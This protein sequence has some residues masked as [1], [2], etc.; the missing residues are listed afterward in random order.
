MATPSDGAGRATTRGCT[1][2]GQIRMVTPSAMGC[3]DCLRIGAWWV[4]LRLCL[5]CGHVGCCDS[6]PNRHASAHARLSG[7]PIVRSF[8]PGE[9]WAWCYVDEVVIKPVPA[10]GVG[11]GG[12]GSRP[13]PRVVNVPAPDIRR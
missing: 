6:S 9:D 12:R 5:T 2:V 3:V 4:H 11:R 13:T 1:H 10:A 7:H 8:E